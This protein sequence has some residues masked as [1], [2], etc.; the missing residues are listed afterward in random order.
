MGGGI[1]SEL[2]RCLEIK[3]EPAMARGL[4]GSTGCLRS[5][6]KMKKV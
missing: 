1:G 4:A 2:Y 6:E 3:C 5:V